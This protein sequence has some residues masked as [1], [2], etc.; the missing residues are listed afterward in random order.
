LRRDWGGC[1]AYAIA[2]RIN[3]ALGEE[4]RA[5][6][7]CCAGW[8]E[9]V[10]YESVDEGGFAHALRAEDYDLGLERL[11]HGAW[12]FVGIVVPEKTW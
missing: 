2:L 4:G 11:R 10:L 8:R 7:A 9:L 5:D 6:C 3:N 12:F 1:Q